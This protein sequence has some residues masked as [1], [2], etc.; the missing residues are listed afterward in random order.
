MGEIEIINKEISLRKRIKQIEAGEA[1][2]DFIE[3][4][5]VNYDTQFFHEII[6]NKL[7]ELRERKIKKLMVFMPPQHGKST[8]SSM[9]F[10]AYLLGR[11]PKEKIIIGCYNKSKAAEFVTNTAR[12]IKGK[13]YSEVFPNTKLSGKDTE[14]LFEVNNGQGY[15]KGAGLD[16]GVTGSTASC[17]II[18]D[19]FKGR[20]QAN[21]KTIRERAWNSYID[22][23]CTRLDNMGI[24]LMLFTRWHDDDLAG[25]LLN[26]KNE[27]YDEEEAK[28]WEVLVFQALKEEKLPIEG[29]LEYEDFREVDQA[30][31]ET[32]HSAAKYIK[33]R[34]TSP[35]SFN[36]LDQQRPNAEEGNKIRR[37]WLQIIDENLLPFNPQSIVPDYFI[38][39]AYTEKVQNDETGLLSCFFHKPTGNLYIFNC[40]GVRK[41][42]NEL[43]IYFIP[44]VKQNY[45]KSRSS[46][47][48]EMK[49]SGPALKSMLSKPMFGSFN[50]REIPNKVV[51]YGKFNRVE[52]SEPFLASGK[53]FLVKGPWNKEFVDQCA[54]F[55]NGIHDDMVDVLCYAVDKYFIASTKGGVSYN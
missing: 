50:T 48:I 28:E 42:L 16:S 47:Y 52:N 40:S 11:N 41:E 26:P 9:N 22:D 3:Y 6:C 12:I 33:R 38:D 32:K 24:Q 23:F 13:P 51:G 7:D 5:D 30:L 29:A 25:R 4:N 39:G 10:P 36:S 27:H 1:L 46:V 49:S 19:P 20:N 15:V 31:W 17:I 34:R 44:Y 54:A 14:A 2:V 18:D 35:T 45:Y 43:L 53:V 8:I 55:P 21:S 37:E